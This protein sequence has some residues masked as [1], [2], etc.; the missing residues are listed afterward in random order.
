MK[1]LVIVE[2]PTK[3][4]KIKDY[5]GKDYVVEASFG[6]VRDLPQSAKDIPEKLK[7][8]PLARL[9]IDV[10]RGFTPLY[11]VPLDKKAQ[12]SKL[13]K[14]LEDADHVYLATDEDREGEAIAWHLL[15]VLKPTVPVSRMARSKRSSAPSA[16]RASSTPSSCVR[17]RRGASSTACTATRS[18]PSCGARSPRACRRGVCSRWRRNCSSSARRNAWRSSRPRGGT[19]TSA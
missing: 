1:H 3:A 12:I 6:H 4:K 9:G 5:L 13:K 2:S 15:E 11:I 7:K 16:R 18:R 19:S 8:E 10:D 17:R 14:L